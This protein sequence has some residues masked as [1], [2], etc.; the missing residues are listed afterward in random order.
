M[1]YDGNYHLLFFLSRV[2]L[3][4]SKFIRYELYLTKILYL[5]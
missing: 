4:Q 2:Q 1:N 3:H 5:M